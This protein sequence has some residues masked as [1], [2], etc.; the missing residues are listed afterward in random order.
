MNH[1]FSRE[2]KTFVAKKESRTP[3]EN[4]DAEIRVGVSRRPPTL[5]QFG[6][7]AI[8]KLELKGSSVSFPKS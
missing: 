1:R 3:T 2:P 6:P 7:N 5:K 8:F 4:F